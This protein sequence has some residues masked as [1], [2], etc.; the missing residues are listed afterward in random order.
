MQV[1]GVM[2]NV[3]IAPMHVYVHVVLN[4][5]QCSCLMHCVQLETVTTCVTACLSQSRFVTGLVQ[6]RLL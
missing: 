3:S 5:V 6:A 4:C 2:D 1:K